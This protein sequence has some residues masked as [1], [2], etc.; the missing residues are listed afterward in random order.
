MFEIRMARGAVRDLER[1]RA[2]DRVRVVDAIERCLVEQPQE[3]SR[4]R[5][6]LSALVPPWEHAPPVWE[7]RVDDY[8][9]FYDVDAGARLVVI[10]A[11]RRKGR[12]ATGEIL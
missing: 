10:R 9:V 2:R 11:V 3:P 8:R 5:K 4:N 12:L 6:E 1:L 7:L